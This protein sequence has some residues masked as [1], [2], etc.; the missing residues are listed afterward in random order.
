MHPIDRVCSEASFPM[1]EHLSSEIC[2]S[3]SRGF[4]FFKTKVS[5]PTTVILLIIALLS[6]TRMIRHVKALCSSVGRKEML[7][8][9]YLYLGSAALEAVLVGSKEFISKHTHLFLTSIQLSLYTSAF[10]SLFVGSITV[11]MFT[12]IFGLGATTLLKIST[13]IYSVGIGTVIFTGLSTS[14]KELTSVPF[15]VLNPLFFFL[16]MIFQVKRLRKTDGEVWAYGT[17]IISTACFLI[18]NTFSFLGSRVIGLMTDRY[19]DNLFFYHFFILCTFI[20]V[21]KYWLSVY[22]YEVES[23]RLEV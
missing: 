14:S 1:C 9:F 7:V 6:A 8:F 21:H 20:M 22:N 12:R 19:F 13:G 17:L 2:K 11:D 3:T 15:F 10:F 23:L 16:Y 18:A 4:L 5:S